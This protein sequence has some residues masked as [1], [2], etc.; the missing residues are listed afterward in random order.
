MI[1]LL[2]GLIVGILISS[3]LMLVYLHLT[4]AMALAWI[5]VTAQAIIIGLSK[6]QQINQTYRDD[7]SMQIVISQ[8]QN[9]TFEII[10]SQISATLQVVNKYYYIYDLFHNLSSIEDF[11]KIFTI[12]FIL[13]LI[14]IYTIIYIYKH[15]KNSYL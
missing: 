4:T 15:H 9:T 7:P 11:L 6:L 14:I 8:A 13:I 3:I 5:P 1:S 2:I 10:N 12:F